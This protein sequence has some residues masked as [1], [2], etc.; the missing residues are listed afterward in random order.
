M[1]NNFCK[2]CG[3]KE[4]RLLYKKK[5]YTVVICPQCG[6]CWVYPQ[7]SD[8]KLEKIKLSH[9]NRIFEKTRPLKKSSMVLITQILKGDYTDNIVG[10]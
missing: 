4:H 5:D 1:N 9:K 8:E 6:F 3:A 10:T 7:P 2:V